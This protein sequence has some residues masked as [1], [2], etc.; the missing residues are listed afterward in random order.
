[1]ILMKN[2]RSFYGFQYLN[3]KIEWKMLPNLNILSGV[4]NLASKCDCSIAFNFSEVTFHSSY[5]FFRK[6]YK[7]YKNFMVLQVCI[8]YLNKKQ[9]KFLNYE[10]CNWVLSE[11]TQKI[12]FRVVENWSTGDA[13]HASSHWYQPLDWWKNQYILGNFRMRLANS[14]SVSTETSIGTLVRQ[15]TVWGT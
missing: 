10:P 11:Y 12:V 7:D 3:W 15:R 1:M 2:V 5:Q 13:V 4:A 14:R 9:C 6:F 8:K